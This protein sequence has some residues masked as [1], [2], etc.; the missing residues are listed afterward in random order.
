MYA[1]VSSLTGT[2]LNKSTFQNSSGSEYREGTVFQYI[3][4]PCSYIYIE[5]NLYILTIPDPFYLYRSQRSYIYHFLKY[6][7]THTHPL[8]IT[9]YLLIYN[10]YSGKLFPKK[11]YTIIAKWFNIS[12]PDVER[13]T[14]NRKF[15]SFGRK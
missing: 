6:T 8:Y 3:I 15:F 2:E 4:F 7:H 5:F 13:Q 11:C 14:L 1:C 9:I 12:C 10:T